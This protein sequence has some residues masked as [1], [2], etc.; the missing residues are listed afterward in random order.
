MDQKATLNIIYTNIGRGHP[1]YLDG[2][3]DSLQ[4][5]YTDR[6][7]LK[8]TDVFAV[9]GGLALMLWKAVRFMYRAGSQGGFIGRF[10][11]SLRRS[12]S[13]GGLGIV[14]RNLAGGL[15]HFVK[16]NRHPTLVA[17]PILVPMISDLVPVY[18]QH[19][20]IAV[21]GEAVVSGA[22]KVFLPLEECRD[23]FTGE[24]H[25]EGVPVVSGLC[26]ESGIAERAQEYFDARV[27]R[28]E[29]DMPLTGAFFSSGAE[30][31]EHVNRIIM[32]VRSLVES[33]HKAIIFCKE[34]GRLMRKLRAYPG[35]S[36]FMRAFDQAEFEH[37]LDTLKMVAVVFRN[38][39]EENDLTTRCFRY[40]DYFAAPSHERTNWAV[41]LGLPMFVLHPIIGTFS[42]LNHEFL[43]RHGVAIDINIDKKAYDFASLLRRLRNEDRLLT[44]ARNGYGRY[45]TD[46]FI[47]VAD[48][49]VND[50]TG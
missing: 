40:F 33:G 16:H 3:V 2:V 48:A 50:L 20:E 41:G 36:I 37:N 34:G 26:I 12:R 19:G 39:R 27:A 24:K 15:R 45:G 14:E 10:Y 5:D 47:T 13:A 17:H 43:T 49:I 32:A 38:R 25:I 29:S 42:P 11:E 44:M 9:S 6:I 35:P 18:Y 23:R 28:I 21:P 22:R 1:Y 31:R 8:I 4:T 7:E 30:P 46:G